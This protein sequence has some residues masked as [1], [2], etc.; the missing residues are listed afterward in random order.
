MNTDHIKA[1]YDSIEPPAELNGVVRAAL[2]GRRRE[3][4]VLRILRTAGLSAAALV[5]TFVTLLNVSPAF[6]EAAY[7]LPGLSGLCRVF[8]LRHY[9]FTDE[10]KTVDVTIPKIELGHSELEAR[11]NLE[12]TRVVD[13]EMA[14]ATQRAQDYY[15]AYI[16]TGGDPDTYIPFNIYVDYD[17]HCTTGDIVSFVVFRYETR[18]SSY[19]V[20]HYYNIDL[21][22]GRNVTLR[23]LLG[24]D[25]RAIVTEQVERQIEDLDE[26]TARCLFDFVDISE[27]IDENRKFYITEDG[28]DIV[29]VFEKYEI[30]AGAA[31]QLEF[32]IPR[33][34]VG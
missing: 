12:I 4:P 9:D 8:T 34:P 22:T 17:V 5:L 32:T 1:A 27:L 7:Q 18:A 25:Y 3:R 19:C 20:S 23:D 24:S 14:E 6:A 15:D 2:S 11:I 28:E 26:E 16:A 31:G 13:A 33:P 29:V 30:A 21:E 10:S